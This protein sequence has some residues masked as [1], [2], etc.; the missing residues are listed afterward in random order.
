MSESVFNE[1]S[2]DVD[3]R[4][5]GS[6][7]T[8]AFFVEGETDR[9]G[10]GTNDPAAILDVQG[11]T[12]SNYVGS[13]TNTSSTGWGAFV[14]GGADNADY[15]L[16]VQDKDANDL[17]SVKGGGRIG[18][19]T[20]DPQALTHIKGADTVVSGTY[21]EQLLIEDTAAYN[22]AQYAGISFKAQYHSNGSVAHI[23]QI[24]GD[25][26]D[27]GSGT[28]N[29]QLYFLT[30][31]SGSDLEKALTLDYNQN[32]TFAGNL[33]VNGTGSDIITGDYLYLDAH[34]NTAA[35]NLVFRQLDDTW[36]GQIEFHPSSTSQIVTRVNQPLAFGV[37]NSHKMTIGTDGNVAIGTSSASP[38]NNNA[39]NLIIYETGDDTGITLVA[40]NDRGSNI[41]FA[42]AEDDNVGGITYNHNSN[43]MN[44]RINGSERMRITSGG[45]IVLGT[46]EAVISTNTSDGSDDRTFCLAGGGS[47]STSRGSVIVLCGN[48]DG[49]DG[50]LL[51]YAGNASNNNGMIHFYTGNSVERGK[52]DYS[53]DFYTNDG[54]VSSLAS[55]KRVKNSIANISDGLSIV[56]QLRPVTFK[57]TNDSEF[58]E[59]QDLSVTR[60]GFI[61]DEVKEIAPQYTKEGK[62]KIG[63]E[64]VDDFKTLSMLK[65][66]PMLV[67]AVQE[68]SEQVTALEGN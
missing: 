19:G 14:K 68:L 50:K 41:Y 15:S 18:I 56:N 29:G 20:N 7:A 46:D 51:L 59:G 45:N 32:A 43:Y 52:F 49:N 9:V 3:F 57:Y 63:D 36:L 25:R 60:Y 1:G 12:G 35:K 61:A 62:G 64:E 5:E 34:N 26:P 4:V 11:S 55:D 40:D 31:T 10:I 44:F 37:N 33:T 23:A 13:F 17:L 2:V 54:S 24:V 58:H 47:C 21:G 30:R 38:Y 16:R 8:H 42:D 67:K 27:T 66:F 65:M 39:D 53:G 48:E 28:Y 22:A 6:G